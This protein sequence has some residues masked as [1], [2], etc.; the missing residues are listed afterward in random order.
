ME[1]TEEFDLEKE[2]AEHMAACIEARRREHEAN[3][4]PEVREAAARIVDFLMPRKI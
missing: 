2:K 4:P 3:C 1:A